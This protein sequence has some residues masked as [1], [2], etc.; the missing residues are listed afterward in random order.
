[1]LCIGSDPNT[2]GPIALAEVYLHLKGEGRIWD[3][4]DLLKSLLYVHRTCV[5]QTLGSLLADSCDGTDE[6][7]ARMIERIED[8]WGT[9]T[10]D[11]QSSFALLDIFT[12]LTLASMSTHTSTDMVK[13]IFEVS[14]SHALEVAGMQSTNTKSRPYL[15]W[16]IAKVL[17]EQYVDPNITGYFALASHLDKLPGGHYD[18][19]ITLPTSYMI[20]YAPVDEE[21]PKWQPDPTTTLGHDGALRTVLG[22]AE[23][24][25]DAPLQVICLE[26]LIYQ[27]PQPKHLLDKLGD[28]WHSLGSPG[29]FLE[30]RIYSYI[31]ASLTTPTFRETIR[32]EILLAGEI[33][34]EGPVSH[35]RAMVLR[36]LSR[37]QREKDYYES[38]AAT[39]L[40]RF[41]QL[42]FAPP[43][44]GTER[45]GMSQVQ[46]NFVAAPRYADQNPF[47]PL[48]RTRYY[49]EAEPFEGAPY[50]LSAAEY[51]MSRRNP[52]YETRQTMRP[53][54]G[55]VKSN[56]LS[57]ETSY[58]PSSIASLSGKEPSPG[59]QPSKQPQPVP[60]P[61]P[62]IFNRSIEEREKL[63]AELME[64][65]SSL[66]SED[67]GKKAGSGGDKQSNVS[68]T[69]TTSFKPEN[70][71]SREQRQRLSERF[72]SLR[73]GD[74]GKEG[75]R[76]QVETRPKTQPD[77]SASAATR[78]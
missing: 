17:L 54:E 70:E 39:T 51:M 73:I 15:C 63:V 31:P 76:K 34:T 36:A 29:G 19:E 67:A 2:C 25:G 23:E 68:E 4:R 26:L 60:D 69:K 20:V 49:T 58:L 18:P 3:F 33:F 45:P 40:Y 57:Q 48:H 28:L 75:K 22:V 71:L 14:Q 74:G 7:L 38:K 52:S 16:I 13:S 5:C 55:T 43:A 64:N 53:Q 37:N 9:A 42:R 44:P 77:G 27:S 59:S 1:M 65:I 21:A 78:E 12:T 61:L 24:L 8:D 56:K 62:S 50:S 30:T 11:E 72:S 32:R 35:A 10:P 66:M 46:P 41:D 47:D 6:R